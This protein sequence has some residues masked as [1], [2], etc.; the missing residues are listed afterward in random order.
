MP[1]TTLN[2]SDKGR[3]VTVQPGDRFGFLT[4]ICRVE[5]GPRRQVRVRCQCDCGNVIDVYANS[6][7]SGAT[8]SCGCLRRA[9]AR[10]MHKS[11]AQF[12]EAM[13]L[14]PKKS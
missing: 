12:D 13:G 2:K 8:K 7:R 14:G 5:D 4:V 6:L 9:R 1:K 10:L 3:P 11:L